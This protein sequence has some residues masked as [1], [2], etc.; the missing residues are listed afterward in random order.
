MNERTLSGLNKKPA[1]PRVGN[2]WV[3]QWSVTLYAKA[4]PI[5]RRGKE[6]TNAPLGE[7][8]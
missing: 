2:G 3:L 6:I 4:L 1:R 5:L 8:R 7:W